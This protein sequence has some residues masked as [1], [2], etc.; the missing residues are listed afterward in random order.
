LQP[1]LLGHFLFMVQ[2]KLKRPPERPF[3]Y[4][5]KD[6]HWLDTVLS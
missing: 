3:F 5:G 6:I 2:L 4:T 1:P